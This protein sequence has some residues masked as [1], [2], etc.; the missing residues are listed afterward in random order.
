M[1]ADIDAWNDRVRA[2]WDRRV[3]RWDVSAE[4]SR[5]AQDRE[6]EIIRSIEVLGLTPGHRLLDAG[7]G[8]GQ[9][10]IAFSLRGIKVT[11]ID[12]SPQMIARA[13]EH[14]AAYGADDRI[15]FQVGDLARL[16]ESFSG[17]HAIHCRAALHF[18]PDVPAALRE[19]RRVMRSDG[20][21][22]VSVPGA[23]SP[24]YQRSWERH[25][26]AAPPEVNWLTPW[27]L[28]HL[29]IAGGWRILDGWGDYSHDLA[30]TDNPFDQVMLAGLDI[31]LQQAAAT[32]WTVIAG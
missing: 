23:L 3:E 21:L 1:Y 32:M 14:L 8:T 4:A 16:P 28:E 20:R 27:E 24:I 10:A 12:V 22:L 25:L 17:Y 2:A 9:W 15:E 19:F 30:G 13:R 11:A 5:V 6:E 29:L 7:C 31:R 18:M 26:N